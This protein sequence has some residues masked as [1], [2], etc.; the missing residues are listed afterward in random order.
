MHRLTKI[1]YLGVIAA[2][3]LV[4]PALAPTLSGVLPDTAD[5]QVHLH[6]T[7]SAALNLGEA[8]RWPRWSPHL[9]L[10]YGYPIHNFYA[11]GVHIAGG[12]LV[13]AGIAPVTVFLLVQAAGLVLYAAGAYL[14]ALTFLPAR[15]ALLGAAAYA[16]APFRFRELWVQGNL[17]QFVAMGL[18]P[19]VLWA[20]ARASQRPGARRAVVVGLAFGALILTHHPTAFIFAPFAG[21]YAL[22]AAFFER[23]PPQHPASGLGRAAAPHKKIL[24]SLGGLLLGLGLAAIFWLPALAEMRH[25]D[26]DAIERGMFNVSLNLVDLGELLA[27]SPLLDRAALNPPMPHN[28]GAAQLVLAALGA[29]A[30]ISPRTALDRRARACVWAGLAG[31]VVCAAMVLPAAEPVWGALPLGRFIAFPW[32]L[33]GV[34]EVCLVPA[35]AAALALAPKRW[36]TP[37]LLGGLALALLAVAG[38]LYPVR[39]GLAFDAVTPA[40]AVAYEL[41]SGALG[42]VSADEYLPR[43]VED[44]PPLEAPPEMAAYEAM[45]W[46]VAVEPGALPGGVTDTYEGGDIVLGP[47]GAFTLKLR[48]FY[49]PGWRAKVDGA[50]VDIAPSSPDGLITLSVPASGEPRRVEV[51][52]AGTG[53]QALAGWVSAGALAACAGLWVWEW[54]RR[55]KAAASAASP[56]HRLPARTAAVVIAAALAAAAVSQL[57]VYPHTDWLRPR[58]DPAD[59]AA[60]QYPLHVSLSDE[61]G[62]AVELLGYDLE[63]GDAGQGG[64]VLVRLYWRALRSLDTDYRPFVHWDSLTGTETWAN[65]TLTMPGSAPTSRWSG[66]YYVIDA[67]YLDIPEDALPVVGN[68]VAGLFEPATG[69]RLQAPDGRDYVQ[70]AQFRVTGDWPASENDAPA[71]DAAYRFGEAASLTGAAAQFDGEAVHVRL[72]WRADAPLSTD[73][74]IFLHVLDAG[75]ELVTTGDRPPLDGLYPTGLWATGQSIPDT[76]SI[77]LPAGAE[78]P[79]TVAVGL[80]DPA[81]VTRLPAYEP[82]GAR[83]P[84]DAVLLQVGD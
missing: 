2:A 32:R 69:A 31:A 48:Q 33:V 55:G 39:P 73:Y 54:R 67:H 16:Y 84:D 49:F 80:Y 20:I 76:A 23:P 24:S 10:G 25:V 28:I 65:S 40:T 27:P 63:T 83:L 37:A 15:A 79:F 64:T 47:G 35:M 7:V 29:A 61:A 1:P 30:A 38:Y 59:P 72:L 41:Q 19:W 82:A 6:R 58:S 22:L 12:L 3:L 14:F 44:A 81:T 51:W 77:P 74:T 75:G 26:F 62:A 66:D 50:R 17:S 18:L 36:R 11:P 57:V 78:G 71:F 4:L 13:N 46:R 70:L 8:L 9:H 56:A 52:Y 53:V 42:T 5:G 34:A 60:M 68:L 21:G 45:Q 43:W